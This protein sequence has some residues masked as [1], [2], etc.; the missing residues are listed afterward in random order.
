MRSPRRRAGRRSMGLSEGPSIPRRT[1][2]GRVRSARRRA[3]A[4]GSRRGVMPGGADESRSSAPPAAHLPVLYIGGRHRS[5]TTLLE[6]M[7]GQI[8][9]FFAAGELRQIWERGVVERRRCGCER[10]FP[11]C[12]FWTEVGAKAFGGWDGPE[13]TEALALRRALDRP[14]K[15][16]RWSRRSLGGA[17]AERY[18]AIQQRLFRA[19]A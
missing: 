18:A 2:P 15:A 1:V 16:A 13:V 4:G 6:L 10:S 9:G 7:L 5:G 3:A 11:E 8:P 12:P 19:I 17:D 14:G